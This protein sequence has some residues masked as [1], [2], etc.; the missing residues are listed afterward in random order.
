MRRIG[1]EDLDTI[2]MKIFG[3][4]RENVV[5]GL[6]SGSMA[7]MVVEKLGKLAMKKDRKLLGI[8]SSTQIEKVAVAAGYTILGYSHLN[9]VYL[10]IDGA[11]QVDPNLNIIKGGGGALFKERLIW[12]AAKEVHVF[13]SDEKYVKRLNVPI[14]VET[15]PSALELVKG[16]IMRMGGSPTL[17]VDRKGYPNVT[18]N[19]FYILDTKFKGIKDYGKLLKK[20]KLIPGVLEV[21]IFIYDHVN[22]HVIT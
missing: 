22:L 16:H 5:V 8:P 21:G 1:N 3:K 18:E 12:E 19:G 10:T 15:H 7:S 14:P 20:L 17:R 2:V 13:V 11:D 9:E 6:G 4:L